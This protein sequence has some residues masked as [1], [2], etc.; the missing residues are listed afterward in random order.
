LPIGSALPTATAGTVGPTATPTPVGTA[1]STETPAATASSGIAILPSTTTGSTTP[2]EALMIAGVAVVL[3]VALI[4][5]IVVVKPLRLKNFVHDHWV[6]ATNWLRVPFYLALLGGLTIV[7]MQ[8]LYVSDNAQLL[9]SRIDPY[10]VFLF[11]GF[12]AEVVSRT[13]TNVVKPAG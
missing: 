7:G 2:D 8:T 9:E 5:F 6:E 13:L 4:L 12:G 11:W 10:A 3:V 1:S